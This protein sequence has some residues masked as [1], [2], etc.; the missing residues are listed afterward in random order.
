MAEQKQEE[1]PKQTPAEDIGRRAAE[2]WKNAGPRL[3][4]M[5]E[6]TRPKV[7]KAGRDAFEYAR[8]HEDELR[9]AALRLARS[10]VMGPLGIVVDGVMRAAAPASPTA[11][12]ALACAACSASNPPRSRFCNQCG[13]PLTQ[14][15]T[16]QE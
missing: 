5:V 4:G 11:D 9:E 13:S 15:G 12:A 14:P 2:L 16:T 10:R 1:P 8:T 3:S 6:Q 7:E